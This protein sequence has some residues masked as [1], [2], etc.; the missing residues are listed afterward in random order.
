MAGGRVTGTHGQ[1]RARS[2]EHGD[3]R[4]IADRPRRMAAGRPPPPAR[5]APTSRWLRVRRDILR[6][7]N[8]GVIFTNRSNSPT[9]PDANQAYGADASF[10]FFQN[11]TANAYY[12]RSESPELHGDED[13]YQARAEYGGDRYGARLDYLDVGANFFPEIGF[14]QRRGFG[15]TFGLGPLQPA[16]A[17]QPPRPPLPVRGRRRVRRQP[18]PPRRVD[19][20]HRPF[21]DRVPEQRPV[22]IRRQRTPRSCWCGRSP[23]SPGVT[24]AP[25]NYTFRLDHDQLRVRPA[26]PGLGHAWRSQPASSTMARSSRDPERRPRRRHQAAVGGTERDRTTAASCPPAPSPPRCCGPGSTSPSRRCGS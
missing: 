14:V 26:A 16:D 3:R 10:S 21:P 19:Q 24:I 8:V 17:P 18:Q 11:V 13:S 7:S 23:S 6:R 15:R 9:S 4:G 2:D 12:A 20:Q 22:R 25:G 1:D 5:R